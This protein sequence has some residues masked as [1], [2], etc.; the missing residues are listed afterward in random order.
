MVIKNNFE[1]VHRIFETTQKGKSTDLILVAEEH[2]RGDGLGV[3]ELFD[4][5]LAAGVRGRAVRYRLTGPRQHN[6]LK[7]QNLSTTPTASIANP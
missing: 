3:A 4:R 7:I 2:V 1:L 5:V 6:T